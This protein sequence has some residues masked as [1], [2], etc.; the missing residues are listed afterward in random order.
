MEEGIGM[1]SS[2]VRHDITGILRELKKVTAKIRKEE[3]ENDI[4]NEWKFAAM[5]MDR[6]CFVICILFTVGSTL[7]VVA[8]APNLIT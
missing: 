5:V 7:A 4:K 6:M 2:S 8:S 1:T 3:E